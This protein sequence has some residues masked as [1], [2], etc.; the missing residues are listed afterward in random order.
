[1]RMRRWQIA[2]VTVLLIGFAVSLSL[3]IY[4]LLQPPT[5]I[6]VADSKNIGHGLDSQG[7]RVTTYTV[8]LSLVKR[9]D[10]NNIPIGGTLAYIIEKEEFDLIRDGAV[11]EGRPRGGVRLDILNLTHAATFETGDSRFYPKLN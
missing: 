5:I 9:D 8:S 1:M 4:G 6:G 11:I 2:A 7:D 3:N 10:T